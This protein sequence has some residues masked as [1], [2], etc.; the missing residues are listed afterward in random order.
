MSA[1]R[2]RG[3]VLRSG[4]DRR[5]GIPRRQVYNNEYAMTGGLDRRRVATRRKLVRHIVS[6]GFDPGVDKLSLYERRG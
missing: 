1:G 6:Y 4:K 3:L 2:E 5:S